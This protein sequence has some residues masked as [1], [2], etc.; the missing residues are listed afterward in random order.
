MLS[1]ASSG[2]GSVLT[3]FSYCGVHTSAGRI[4]FTRIPSEDLDGMDG[5]MEY[6]ISESEEEWEEEWEMEG[7]GGDDEDGDAL[8]D[9]EDGL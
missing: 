5:S 1:I 6:F 7:G 2:F 9:E 8:G 4:A 3:Q